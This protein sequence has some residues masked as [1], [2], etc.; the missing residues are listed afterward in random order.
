MSDPWVPPYFGSWQELIAELMHNPFL[1]GGDGKARPHHIP[2]TGP[3]PQPWSQSVSFVLSAIS[4]KEVAAR[5]SNQQLKKDLEMQANNAISRFIDD[6]GN[7]LRF[8]WRGP[9]PGPHPPPPFS[10]VFEL[11]LAA[12]T[13]QEGSFREEVLH[14]AADIVEKT[15]GAAVLQ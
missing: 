13:L 15:G 10:I 7:I 4:L 6:C 11:A 12:N 1:G 2:V 9:W 3:G 8:P 5:L 14:V